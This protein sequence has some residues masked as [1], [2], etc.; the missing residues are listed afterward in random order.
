MEDLVNKRTGIPLAAGATK[1]EVL[2]KRMFQMIEIMF[3]NRD[4]V[5]AIQAAQW[6]SKQ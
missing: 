6:I 1:I 5:G 4:K 3:T 2:S